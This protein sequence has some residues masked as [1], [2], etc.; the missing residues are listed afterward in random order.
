MFA[1]T[2]KS[3]VMNGLGISK[4]TIWYETL[5]EAKKEL[6]RVKNICLNEN[7]TNMLDE[8]CI[9]DEDGRIFQ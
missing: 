4:S 2:V 3:L 6:S 5:E 8:M 1:V 9:V 7:L